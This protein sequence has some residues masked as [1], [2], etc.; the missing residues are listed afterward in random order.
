[1]QNTRA[2]TRLEKAHGIYSWPAQTKRLPRSNCAGIS[3]WIARSASERPCD[4]LGKFIGVLGVSGY[5]VTLE[6]SS[7]LVGRSGPVKIEAVVH[8]A[9][10]DAQFSMAVCNEGAAIA[11]EALGK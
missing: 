1:M 9:T 3:L 7:A 5:F 6:G 4:A 11:L 8:E 10:Y 2:R